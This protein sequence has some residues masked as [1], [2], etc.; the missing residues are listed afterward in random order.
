MV[1]IEGISSE[2]KRGWKWI[3]IRC[4]GRLDISKDDELYIIL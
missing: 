4:N 1:G 2:G 3:K